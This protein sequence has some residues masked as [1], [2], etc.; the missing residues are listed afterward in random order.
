LNKMDAE[1]RRRVARHDAPAM[2]I[3]AATGENP[4]LPR[5]RL[6]PSQRI[7]LKLQRMV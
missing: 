2:E 6:R 7:G 4:M 5:D 1:T 3:L